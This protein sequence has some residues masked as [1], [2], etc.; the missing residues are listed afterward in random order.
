MFIIPYLYDRVQK[1]QM[2]IHRIQLLTIGG[3]MVWE[4]AVLSSI[5]EPILHPNGI[6]LTSKPVQINHLLLCEVDPQKT[7]LHDFYTW[8]EIDEPNQ[9]IFCWRTF[10][11]MES[12]QKGWLSMPSKETV[13][14]YPCK[15]L[16]EM[17]LHRHCGPN[18]KEVI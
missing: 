14:P 15:D 6:Y 16:C 17:I 2:T 9:E 1:N 5:E 3:S 10:Y 4:E 8:D 11:L 13:G 18:V 7:D 12:N